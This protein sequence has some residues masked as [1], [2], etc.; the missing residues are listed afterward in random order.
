MGRHSQGTTSIQ[1][2]LSRVS[3][4]TLDQMAAVHTQRVEFPWPPS[5]V[6]RPVPNNPQLAMRTL[7]YRV[8]PEVEH[9]AAGLVQARRVQDFGI[10]WEQLVEVAQ[11]RMRQG[12][13]RT[14]YPD[15]FFQTDSLWRLFA[16]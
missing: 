6:P 13:R 9:R 15:W 7:P 1:E 16:S 8:P 3:D 5:P 4:D 10:P 14:P 12:L 2:L 11:V